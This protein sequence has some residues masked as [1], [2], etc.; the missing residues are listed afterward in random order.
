MPQAEQK[1][2]AGLGK[3]RG[4]AKDTVVLNYK[5]MIID[6]STLLLTTESALLGEKDVKESKGSMI[7]VWRA[8][9]AG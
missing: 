9:P 3:L 8:D 4:P 7:F 5:K 2:G 6:V 1:G